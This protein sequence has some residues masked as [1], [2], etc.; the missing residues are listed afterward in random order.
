[1]SRIVV[2][3]RCIGD[4]IKKIIVCFSQ[5]RRFVL[6]SGG[7]HGE[8]GVRAYTGSLGGEP[9]AGSGAEP[10]SGVTHTFIVFGSPEAGSTKPPEAERKLNFNNTITR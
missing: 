10:W 4:F 5:W 1:M 6:N 3:L 7:R 9:P 8:R 2:R